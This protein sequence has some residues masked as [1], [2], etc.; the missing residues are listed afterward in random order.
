MSELQHCPALQSQLAVVLAEAYWMINISTDPK[1][2][3]G[4][5]L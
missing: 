3:G 5:I 2:S 4:R 1:Q